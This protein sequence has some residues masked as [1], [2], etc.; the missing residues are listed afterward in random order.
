MRT[1]S[2]FNTVILGEV[3]GGGCDE[4]SRGSKHADKK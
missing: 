2:N 4:E 1:E 3:R